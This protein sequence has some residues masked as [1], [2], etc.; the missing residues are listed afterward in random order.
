VGTV[1]S[2]ARAVR[3]VEAPRTYRVPARLTLSSAEAT[4][5]VAAIV[6]MHKLGLD[7]IETV[8]AAAL[9]NRPT[10]GL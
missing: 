2:R 3:F 1:D 4:R 6:V 5:T 8:D 7:R 10:V 9:D